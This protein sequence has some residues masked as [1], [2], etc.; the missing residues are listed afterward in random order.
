[1]VPVPSVLPALCL[2]SEHCTV[3]DSL[4]MMA[5]LPSFKS[6][7][8]ISYSGSTQQAERSGMLCDILF[9]LEE[10]KVGKEEE[11]SQI[12]SSHSIL[13]KSTWMHREKKK[14]SMMS[15][16]RAEG[17]DIYSVELSCSWQLNNFSLEQWTTDD[18]S[19]F[20]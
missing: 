19:C 6:G 13:N 18:Y 1:M 12:F 20:F 5:F 10:G 9:R 11:I 15:V 7:P 17:M 14:Q 8:S 16:K 3:R 2:E 4:H